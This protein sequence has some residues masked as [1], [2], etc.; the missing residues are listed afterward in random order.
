MNKMRERKI[1]REAFMSTRKKEICQESSKNIIK[2][3]QDDGF[4]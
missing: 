1:E 4:Q 2:S 3:I